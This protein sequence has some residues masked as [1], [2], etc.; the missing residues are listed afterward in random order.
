MGHTWTLSIEEQFYAL[1]PLA[2]VVLPIRRLA[3]TIAVLIVAA[4]GWRAAFAYPMDFGPTIAHVDALLVGA[5]V[6]IWGRRL[7]SWIGLVAL[8]L[9]LG[10]AF[11]PF[12]GT[13]EITVVATAVVIMA[14]P[15][16]LEPLAAAGRRSYGA[17]LWSWPLTMLMGVWAMPVTLLAAEASYRLVE[18]PALRLKGPLARGSLGF[19]APL[20]QR[21][22]GRHAPESPAPAVVPSNAQLMPELPAAGA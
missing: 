19:D 20:R 12:A 17:Y 16:A 2:L 7:P 1:W 10:L 4:I 14:A 21:L 6:A 22:S 11:T 15:R 5:A 18:R 9:M 3:A 8:S 13:L